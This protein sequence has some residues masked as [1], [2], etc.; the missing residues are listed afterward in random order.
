MWMVS[1]SRRG[2]LN[3]LQITTITTNRKQRK[4]YSYYCA[5]QMRKMPNIECTVN[6]GTV[7]TE[8]I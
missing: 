6:G 8:S 7:E 4:I 3:E 1:I 5:K 2:E